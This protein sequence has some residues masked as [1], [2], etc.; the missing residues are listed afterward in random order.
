VAYTSS[1]INV[2]TVDKNG[3]VMA[4]A[5]GSASITA[6]YSQ[7]GQSVKVSVAV[8]VPPPV[9]T[10]SPTALSFN[11]QNVGT[12][13]SPQTVTITNVSSNQ[14]LKVGPVSA[15]G[16]FSETDDCTSSSPIAVGG[17]C[18]INVT[19][20]PAAAGSRT[21]VA[22]VPDSMDIV[23]L[24][25]LLAGTGVAPPS[26]S[27][28]SP[29]SGP[30]GTSV[31]IAGANFGATQGSSTV[32]FN[33]TAATPTSWSA[34]SIAVA[35][36]TGATTGNVVVTVR[37]TAS[38]GVNFT[39]SSGGGG[40]I[41]YVQGNSAF[42]FNWTGS[43]TLVY[44][45][46]QTAGNLN[47][48]VVSELNEYSPPAAINSVTDRSG[49]TYVLAVGPT[50]L[51]GLGTQ[52]IYYAKNIAAAAPNANV[53][54]VTFGSTGN[55]YPE[56]R[57]VEYSGLDRVNPLD[58]SIANAGYTCYGCPLDGNMSTSGPATTTNANDLLV[59]ANMV[60]YISGPYTTM[61]GPGFAARLMPNSGDILEDELVGATGNYTATAP[62]SEQ[63]SFIMQ[64]V[65]FRAAQH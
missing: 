1:D 12:S 4:G 56:I 36:P 7:G 27:S 28:L 40:P 61:A 9:L 16:D 38:N 41:T 31:T 42:Q 59:A 37:G 32:T 54:T 11:N 15:M 43:I 49:N 14:G 25:V 5:K 22:S 51:N 57:I 50:A 30:V 34:T 23:P 62:L 63:G 65:A 18:T 20:K 64:M 39:V 24:T 19:F 6:T 2:A 21:G 48:I 13:S 53:V 44:T 60:D 3:I 10:P 46:A 52:A 47:I 8:T 17:M 29:T 33:G 26:I 35:A 55:S 45:A 58:V